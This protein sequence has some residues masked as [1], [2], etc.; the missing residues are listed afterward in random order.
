[1]NNLKFLQDFNLMIKSIWLTEEIPTK[2]RR[3]L[4]RTLVEL[5]Y[6]K[7][8]VK[9][10]ELINILYKIKDKIIKWFDNNVKNIKVKTENIKVE[11]N[12]FQNKTLIQWKRIIKLHTKKETKEVKKIKELIVIKKETQIKEVKKEEVIIKEKYFLKKKDDLVDKFL[13]YDKMDELLEVL[14][15]KK[16]QKIF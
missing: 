12:V 4:I 15:Q 10:D 8:K 5:W 6:I 11:N 1:M 16:K 13:E 2:Q 3:L 9:K 14:K 7:Q